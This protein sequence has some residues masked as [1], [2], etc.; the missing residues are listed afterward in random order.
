MFLYTSGQLFYNEELRLR[1][2]YEKFD[3]PALK[4][5]GKHVRHGRVKYLRTISKQ[6]F[7]RVLLATLEDEF[8]VIMKIPY[9]MSVLRTYAT[10]VKPPPLH[11]S[12]QREYPRYILGVLHG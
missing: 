1:E 12:S 5:V 4:D 7:S 9:W 11:F 8:Q 10:A 6:G 3:V 2:R